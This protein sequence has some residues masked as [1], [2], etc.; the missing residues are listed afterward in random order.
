MLK[1]IY[2]PCRK[3]E[4]TLKLKKH[5]FYNSQCHQ[6]VEDIFEYSISFFNFN[7]SIVNIQCYISF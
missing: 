2:G 1:V 5:M 3:C 7:S 4:D 6:L